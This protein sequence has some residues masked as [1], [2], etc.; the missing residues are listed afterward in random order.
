[1]L[2]SNPEEEKKVVT[3]RGQIYPKINIRVVALQ[4]HH[5]VIAIQ[6]IAL[7]L[8]GPQLASR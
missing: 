8:K 6:R 4:L 5:I 1:M 2:N 7:P 3:V